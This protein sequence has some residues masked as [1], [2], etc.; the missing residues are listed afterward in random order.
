MASHVSRSEVTACTDGTR[1]SLVLGALSGHSLD[2]S[3]SNAVFSINAKVTVG[4]EFLWTNST[5]GG[6]ERTLYSV[7]AFSGGDK[8]LG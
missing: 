2:N 4:V 5:K 7:L 3:A 8:S 1:Q 6:T